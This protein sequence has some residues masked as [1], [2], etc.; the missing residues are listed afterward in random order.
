VGL[1]AHALGTA[2]ALQHDETTGAF[3]AL[4]MALNGVATAL[5]VPALLFLFR[6]TG[7]L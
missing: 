7:L 5:L 4:G 2:R 3:A 6:A 1:T